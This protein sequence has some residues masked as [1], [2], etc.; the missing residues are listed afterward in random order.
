VRNFDEGDYL[1]AAVSD[2][3]Q[4]AKMTTTRDIPRLFFVIT[5]DEERSEFMR[6]NEEEQVGNLQGVMRDYLGIKINIP[7]ALAADW[8][9]NTKTGRS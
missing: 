2:P 5:P 8:P 3:R 1:D 6:R 9:F 4:L 7:P